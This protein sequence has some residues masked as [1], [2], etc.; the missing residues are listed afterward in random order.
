MKSIF[1]EVSSKLN[2]ELR[3]VRLPLGVLRNFNRTEMSVVLF[4]TRNSCSDINP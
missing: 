3:T 2:E 4:K 1:G